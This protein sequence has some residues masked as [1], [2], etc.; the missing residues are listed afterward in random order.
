MN[1][2]AVTL[3]VAPSSI[4]CSNAVDIKS[5]PAG[6]GI[7]SEIKL[8]NVG[9]DNLSSDVAHIGFV[10]T[11]GRNSLIVRSSHAGSINTK[12]GADCLRNTSVS[13]HHV[14]VNFGRQRHAPSST[15]A[16]NLISDAIV[17]RT[18]VNSD[19][20]VDRS[21]GRAVVGG[22][23]TGV[24][25]ATASLETR[26][27]DSAVVSGIQRAADSG[28]ITGVE[29]GSV[30]IS[31][32]NG[33]NFNRSTVSLASLVR[34]GSNLVSVEPNSRIAGNVG[35]SRVLNIGG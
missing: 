3:A 10:T 17:E 28:W 26:L 6:N 4:S 12:S 35:L 29:S 8:G 20:A 32:E 33:V 9:S 14:P 2:C 7:S 1:C 24:A 22:I 18:V 27:K 25:V 31:V 5:R 19:V 21:V 23:N 34:S 16:E 13:L 11:A 15:V 30:V